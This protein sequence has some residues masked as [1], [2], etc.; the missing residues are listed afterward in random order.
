MTPLGLMP[1]GLFLEPHRKDRM[2]FGTYVLIMYACIKTASGEIEC[3][4]DRYN[5]VE[6]GSHDICAGAGNN[7]IHQ[8]AEA[9]G[10]KWFLITAECVKGGQA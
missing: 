10:K 9:A 5:T 8:L 1:W 2:D 4:K 6:Y 3:H 7:L